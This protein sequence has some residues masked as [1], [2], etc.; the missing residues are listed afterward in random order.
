MRRVQPY[1]KRA[2]PTRAVAPVAALRDRMRRSLVTSAPPVDPSMRARLL[3][4][5]YAADLAALESNL[6]LRLVVA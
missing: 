1:V 3:E 2:L 5:Y 4:D 6:G